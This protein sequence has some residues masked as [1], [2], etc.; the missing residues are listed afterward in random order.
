MPLF[1]PELEF[2]D[3]YPTIEPSLKLNFA[4][5][6]ALD[7]R[8]T[9]TRA[10]TATYVG[11]DGLIKT[12]GVNEARFDHDPTTGE[13]L[14][15]LI[16]EERTNL[17]PNGDQIGGTGWSNP[18]SNS[19]NL[20]TNNPAPTGENVASTWSGPGYYEVVSGT[21]DGT[22]YMMSVYA[23]QNNAGTCLLY[24]SPSPRD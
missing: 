2:S 9:F 24:T 4:D 21:T 8:I 16:E 7:P 19:S 11:R 10:S 15:L 22:T 20:S 17:I 14:G 3:D 1:T 23:K 13:S 18:G 6:R 12:A 5:A